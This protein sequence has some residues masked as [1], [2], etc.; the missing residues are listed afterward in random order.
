MPRSRG[1]AGTQTCPS[2]AGPAIPPAS[3]SLGLPTCAG[4]RGTQLTGLWGGGNHRGRTWQGEP[5][6]GPRSSTH[7]APGTSAAQRVPSMAPACAQ[8]IHPANV[9]LRPGHRGQRH[10][11]EWGVPP[12]T[13]AFLQAP[14]RRPERKGSHECRVSCEG[15]ARATTTSLKRNVCNFNDTQRHPWWSVNSAKSAQKHITTP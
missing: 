1:L 7:R 3:R 10:S 14:R 2:S 13:P 4:A 6:A 9:D 5:T 15:Q 11:G 8:E 12:T